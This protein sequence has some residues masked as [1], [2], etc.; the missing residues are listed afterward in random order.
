[1]FTKRPH[2]HSHASETPVTHAPRPY[3]HASTSHKYKTDPRSQ[4][5]NKTPPRPVGQTTLPHAQHS[6]Q[7]YRTGG[8][9]SWNKDVFFAILAHVWKIHVQVVS[10]T[11]I[12]KRPTPNT[13]LEVYFDQLPNVGPFHN[14]FI[15]TTDKSSKN[16]TDLT[17]PPEFPSFEVRIETVFFQRSS[18]FGP[19]LTFP[20]FSV[21]FNFQLRSNSFSNLKSGTTIVIS[22]NHTTKLLFKLKT[23]QNH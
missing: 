7:T 22:P 23:G 4:Y 21:K 8:F 16:R 9:V 15:Q 11:K 10:G 13:F 12:T 2:A 19:K 1:M 20:L 18:S 6:V 14:L 3:T 17:L 5:R